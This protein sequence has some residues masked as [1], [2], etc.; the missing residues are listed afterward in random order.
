MFIVL[1]Y[2]FSSLSFSHIIQDDVSIIEKKHFT[3]KYV[4]NKSFPTDSPLIEVLGGTQLDCMSRKLNVSDFCDKEL[5]SDPY[6]LRAYID[7][8]KNEVICLTG[9]RVIFKYVCAKLADRKLC[10]PTS[11]KACLKIQEKLAR[12]LDVIHASFTKN[13]KTVKQ[14]NCIFGSI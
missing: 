7:K 6:Y 4:C 9:K 14:L 13:E 8:N 10:S 1:L 3:F 11:K 2:F 12:R 5:M